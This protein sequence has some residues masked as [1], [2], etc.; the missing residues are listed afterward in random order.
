M[1]KLL[2]GFLLFVAFLSVT[3]TG[4]AQSINFQDGFEDGNFT[5]HPAWSGDTQQ[6]KVADGTPNHLLQLQGD[7]SGAA[8]LSTPSNNT[9]G[10]WIFY[11]DFHGF[12]PSGHNQVTIFL[13]SNIANLEGPVNGYAVQ[14]GERGDDVFHLVRYDNGKKAA[15]I[16]SDTT[17]IHK[18]S[19]GYTV[20]VT[21]HNSGIW[22]IAVGRGYG[23]QL[24]NAGH[25]GADNSY[26]T[27]SYFG[28]IAHY[29]KSR[30]DKF[31][32][33]FKIDLPPLAITDIA[34]HNDTVD[35]TFNRPFDQSSVDASNFS[36]NKGIGHPAFIRFPAPTIAELHY[37]NTLPSNKYALSIQ[38]IEDLKGN[39]ITHQSIPF[40]IFGDYHKGDI[41]INE[42][43]YDPIN[44]PDDNLPDQSEYIELRNTKDYAVSLQGITFHDAP[45]ENGNVRTLTP[46]DT[47]QKYIASK[48]TALIYAD[49]AAGFQQSRIARFFHLDEAP[50]HSIIR[51]DRKTL[52]LASSGDAVYL[53]SGDGKTIDSVYYDESWQNPNLADSKG[54]ALERINPNGPSNNASN[55]GSSTAEAGGTPGQENSLYQTPAP[56]KRQK[57][58]IHF[59]PN[60]FSPDGDGR[61]DHLFINYK[62]DEPDYL[63]TVDI[64][65]RFGRKVRTLANDK[66]AGLKGSLI[67][68]GLK[69]DGS[70]N[71]I[72][73]YIVIFKAY[74]AAT[75]EKKV[76]KKTVVLARRLD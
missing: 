35:I 76:F 56:K 69:D 22:Q 74:N 63:I 49:K 8:Y 71:R 61:D 14:A 27:A 1:Q 24:F 21:R 43:M 51:I 59:S 12:E 9:T 73:I 25:T 32:F 41:V 62:L 64:Y 58:G 11:I 45:D 2:S 31:Y 7:G 44:N 38:H 3:E 19:G 53:A 5:K 28:L 52:S 17:V 16:I 30:A 72:G 4:Y 26:T 60:P 65:D 10:S 36:I 39:S 67:W 23:G 47:R 68:D 66:P 54:I 57:A 34:A 46:V 70:R 55:W 6:F 20:K 33:D 15:A 13:M 75:G 29:T 48:G 42:I 18:N 50:A 40:T 37:S